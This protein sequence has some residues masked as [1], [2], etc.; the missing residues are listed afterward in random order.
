MVERFNGIEEVRSSTLLTSTSQ[1]SGSNRGFV[2]CWVR[3]GAA[4]QL[5]TSQSTTA[6][7][8]RPARRPHLRAHFARPVVR[9]NRSFSKLR[10][11]GELPTFPPQ[12]RGTAVCGSELVPGRRSRPQ[13]PARPR[14]TVPA[15][16][17]GAWSRDRDG[18]PPRGALVAHRAVRFQTHSPMTAL[19]FR[20]IAESGP[21][22]S[23]S[24][25]PVSKKQSPADG[26]GSS[27]SRTR[28]LP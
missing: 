13:R 26:S 14:L 20:G 25:C 16:A 7:V 15:A 19:G 5:S 4:G 12:G 11:S 8:V 28:S 24:N 23:P 18:G 6:P 2:R 1:S 27:L 3:A 17:P 22:E 9:L 21:G 10:T